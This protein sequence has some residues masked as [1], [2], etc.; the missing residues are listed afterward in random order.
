L[1]DTYLCCAT[2]VKL[3]D[4]DPTKYVHHQHH[5]SLK[6]RVHDGASIKTTLIYGSRTDAA[7]SRNELDDWA[8]NPEFDVRYAVGFI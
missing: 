5:V 2:C 3:F 8:K 7:P 6:K 4:K 1:I